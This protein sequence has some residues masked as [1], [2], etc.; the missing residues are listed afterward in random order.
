MPGVDGLRMIEADSAARRR[1][2]RTWA[3]DLLDLEEGRMPFPVLDRAGIRALLD[4]KPRVAIVGASPSPVRPSH[5]VL[6]D[7][8]GLGF[9]VVPV[10]PAAE[11]VAGLRC[12]PT[13]RAAVDAT[14]PVDLVDVFRL[15]P[16]CPEHAR[17][18]VEV[19]ASC[20]WLQLGIASRD[21]GEIAHEAGLALVMNRCIAVEAMRG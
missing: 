5:G 18:A 14:G 2:R 17:E 13:L 10:N 16:A 4:T 12:Y 9:D 19:G 1:E 3:V 6:V 21:A 8:V 20:L 11:E 7:L 15:P